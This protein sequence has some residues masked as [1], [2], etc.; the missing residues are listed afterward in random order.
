MVPKFGH[1]AVVIYK[2]SLCW[3][4][5]V[6]WGGS[7]LGCGGAALPFCQ[8]NADCDDGQICLYQR[9]AQVVEKKPTTPPSVEPSKKGLRL[10]GEPCDPRSQGWFF[11]RCAPGHVCAM[12]GEKAPSASGPSS[13]L[14][15][16]GA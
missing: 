7:L 2:I 3:I 15:L 14:E 6:L 5:W 12:L 8:R 4:L 16:D 13:L 9:C 1:R 11:D 10:R